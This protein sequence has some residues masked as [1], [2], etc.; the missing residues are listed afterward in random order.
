MFLITYTTPKELPLQRQINSEK[1]TAC[2]WSTFDLSQL[3]LQSLEISKNVSVPQLHLK[4]VKHP[5]DVTHSPEM[6]GAVW[7]V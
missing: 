4:D 7:E 6:V 2:Q 1:E 3:L 5:S